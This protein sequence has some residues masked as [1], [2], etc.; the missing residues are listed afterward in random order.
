MCGNSLL[1][2]FEGI[3]FYN[4]RE[5]EGEKQ[6]TLLK[7]KEEE[8]YEKKIKELEKKI[9][10]YFD[11][12]DDKEKIKAREEINKLKDWFIITALEKRKEQLNRE[13]KE[14]QRVA[15]FLNEKSRKKYFSQWG[16]VFLSKAKI[17]E[18]LNSIHNPKKE[19][20]FFLWK[21]EFVEV[22][23]KKGGFDIVIAN[24][25]YINIYQ[26]PPRE[27]N[28][29][30]KKPRLFYSAL[31]KF[32]LYVLF[33]EKGL[34]LLRGNGILCFI[35]SNK[36]LSQG[37]GKGIRKLLLENNI[38][39]IINFNFKVFGA[40][41]ETNILIVSKNKQAKLISVLD[42]YPQ[43]IW[44]EK[45]VTDFEFNLDKLSLL[46]H[47][48]K[49]YHKISPNLFRELPQ[50]NFRLQVDQ[51][52][53][54][55]KKKIERGS[56]FYRDI[57]YINKGIVV[58][59]EKYKKKKSYFLHKENPDGKFKKF[60]DGKDII[61]W[62]AVPSMYLD[63]QPDKHYVSYFPELFTVPKL[64][65]KRIIGKNGIQ[66]VLDESDNYYISDNTIFAILYKDLENVKDKIQGITEEKIKTSKNFSL[67]Y[68][69][70]IANSRLAEWYYK[71]FLS[72]GLHFYPSHLQSIPVKKTPT[73]KQKIFNILVDK[74][75]DIAN[76]EDYPQNNSKWREIKE[77]EKELEKAIIWK[78]LSKDK[79]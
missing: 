56:I 16:E 2:E 29:Y 53:F 27:R 67:K 21:L 15:D 13:I 43:D 57:C 24:P 47:N 55:L 9:K 19:K 3:K 31:Q 10:E 32:D 42:L 6:A 74:I 44:D 64:V 11:I 36:W 30:L 22:F 54:L 1:E 35:T 14:K 77:Y 46:L 65:F 68:L 72:I 66:G 26:I 63:Y 71:I 41:V 7:Q 4:D 79:K 60:I 20:P 76:S 69:L 33:M 28:Y 78:S 5:K 17:D 49:S 48:N 39:K 8:E 58:H 34:M 75:I 61:R 23:H 70:G 12:H 73:H 40:T 37:Y 45:T 62:K 18:V 38:I 52:S 25:P 59:S 50:F 51:Q